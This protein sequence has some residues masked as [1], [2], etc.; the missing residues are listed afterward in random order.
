MNNKTLDIIQVNVQRSAAVVAQLNQR[1]REYNL[2]LVAIR[3][4][5]FA[6]A[7]V[8]GFPLSHILI[9]PKSEVPM[10]AAICSK[11]LDPIILSDHSDSHVLVMS[12]RLVNRTII[13]INVYCQFSDNIDAYLVKIQN[14]LN[15]FSNKKII[16]VM[17]A[18]AKSPLWCSDSR[19]GKGQL[20]EDFICSNG[21]VC[22]NTP[23]QPSTFCTVNGESNIDVTLVSRELFGWVSGWKVEVDWCTSDHR[24]LITSLYLGAGEQEPVVNGGVC[25]NLAKADWELFHLYLKEKAEMILEK[26]YLHADQLAETLQVAVIESA[27]CSIP[28][29]KKN[30]IK[31]NK[32]WNEELREL[33]KRVR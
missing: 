4:P 10:G 17:D 16:I 28:I 5:Y 21:L 33:R 26:K 8:R 15:K 9:K 29:R 18:N 11:E 1:I 14:V 13:L 27:S 30:V 19:D 6:F 22:L 31:T 2:K 24:P 12:F 25:F 32:W 20:L 7:N 23:G 3:E